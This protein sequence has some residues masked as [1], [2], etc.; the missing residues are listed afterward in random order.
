MMK[1]PIIKILLQLMIVELLFIAILK[2][3]MNIFPYEEQD[4]IHYTNINLYFLISFLIWVNLKHSKLNK[5]ILILFGVWFT[6]HSILSVFFL[7][8][9]NFDYIFNYTFYHIWNVHNSSFHLA[10]T[11]FLFFFSISPYKKAKLHILWSTLLT[12]IITVFLYVPLF[13]DG[14]YLMSYDNLFESNF[15][16]YILNFSFL[17]VF[18][19]QYTQNK[20]ILSEYLSNIITVYTFIIAIEIFFMFSFQNK[21]IFHFF[22]VHFNAILN[23]AMLILLLVRLNYLHH[24]ESRQ[25]EYYI[26]NYDMLY[27][28]IDKP[29]PGKLFEM[30]YGLNKFA[31]FGTMSLLLILGFSLFLFNH[32][33]IFIKLNIL[34]LILAIIVSIIL[35]VISWH[36]RWSD[37]IGFL[38]K[39]R[40]K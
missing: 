20:V 19:Q 15:Y 33:E 6:T 1:R 14:S 25:N 12:L 24:P 9:I 37:A 39:K 30:Y 7:F 11:L 13:I 27:G 40:K 36:K 32:F 3:C 29:R 2:M 38:F 28:L 31:V 5:P 18:W 16:I 21:L 26:E 35:A 23:M 34:I 4:L 17:V 10:I 22:G 8:Y